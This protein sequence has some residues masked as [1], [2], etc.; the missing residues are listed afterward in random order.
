[1]LK[2]LKL[3]AEYN[4]WVN[5]LLID[6]I[7]ISNS[8]SGEVASKLNHILLGDK[9]WLSRFHDSLDN[10]VISK[11]EFVTKLDFREL[12]SFEDY[13]SQRAALDKL[14]I[15]FVNSLTGSELRTTINYTLRDGQRYIEPFD[16]LILHLFNHQTHHRGQIIMLL[17]QQG[18]EC[19]LTDLLGYIRCSN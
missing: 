5:D 9:L 15:E 18:I 1:M 10:A 17:T 4:L 7:S 14:I 11:C 6:K 8:F 3:F 2:Q 13:R 12:K 16:E 19:G